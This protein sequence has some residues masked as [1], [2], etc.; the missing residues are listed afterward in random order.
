MENNMEGFYQTY[1]EIIQ[2]IETSIDQRKIITSLVLLYSAIDSFSNISNCSDKNGREVFKDWVDRWMLNNNNL[3]CSSIDLYAAR[4]GILHGFISES[5]FS[6]KTKAK[7]ICYAWGNSDLQKLKNQIEKTDA[8]NECIALRL[9]DLFIAFK[10]E[11]AN[12]IDEMNKNDNWKTIFEMK[13]TKYFI[14]MN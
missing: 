11:V 12:C 4:C 1:Y 7:R 13:A 9:E 5:D 14:S 10:M 3:K 6:K 8:H 2:S